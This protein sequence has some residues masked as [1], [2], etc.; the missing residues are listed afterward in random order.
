MGMLV[1]SASTYIGLLN[2]LFKALKLR[3]ENHT[4]GVKYVLELGTSLV[5]FLDDLVV[6]FYLKLKKNKVE[7]TKF[8]FCL[9]ITEERMSMTVEGSYIQIIQLK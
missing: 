3:L 9:D 1:P 2:I 4:I 5:K 6:D 8:P 7:K